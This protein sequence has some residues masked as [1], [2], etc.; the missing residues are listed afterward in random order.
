MSNALNAISRF[1]V[2]LVVLLT[3]LFFL[4][5]TPEFLEF[6]KQYLLYGAVTIG[7]LSWVLRGFFERKLTFTRTPF[8][9]P[10]LGFWLVVLVASIFSKDHTASFF[11]SY[12]KLTFGFVPITFYL[13]LYYLAVNN[14]T[15][16]KHLHSVFLFLGLGGVLSGLYFFSSVFGLLAPRSYLPSWNTFSGTNVGFGMGQFVILAVALVW[17]LQ[18]QSSRAFTIFWTTVAAI[19]FLILL[20]LGYKVLFLAGA[21]GIGIILIF[22]MVN[23]DNLRV[24]VASAAL[25]MFLIFLIFAIFGGLRVLTVS[26]LPAEVSLSPG[27]SWNIATNTL[28]EGFG[29]A[30]IGSG[31]GTFAYD[32]SAHRPESFNQNIFW[33]LR[34]SSPMSESAGILATLGV[35]GATVLAFLAV[36]VLWFF[37][38]ARAKLIGTA[39]LQGLLRGTIGVWFLLF[40]LLFFAPF[41]TVLWIYFFLFLALVSVLGAQMRVRSEK[42]FILSFEGTPQSALTTSFSSIVAIAVFLVLAIYLGRFYAAE[43]HFKQGGDAASRQ[44]FE[45]AILETGAAAELN[46]ARPRYYLALTRLQFQ[47]ALLTAQKSE[48]N[49][50]LVGQLVSAAVVN[51]RRATELAPRLSAAWE[52]LGNVYTQVI[53]IAPD[54]RGWAQDAYARA[55]DLEPTNPVLYVMRAQLYLGEEKFEEA[56]KDVNRAIAL[57]NNYAHAYTARATILSGKN[58]LIG[59]IEAQEN[60]FALARGDLNIAVGLAQLYYNRNQ[61][62]DWKNAETLL[63]QIVAQ[64]SDHANALFTLGLLY[65]R[66]G[67]VGEALRQFRKVQELNPGNEEVL[68]KIQQLSGQLTPLIPAAPTEE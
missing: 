9:L 37:K 13:A 35:L 3:P 38:V 39:G 10:L 1:T 2:Y 40:A 46:P 44:E 36:V 31:P 51:A 55:L 12:D 65:E 18:K 45:S 48:S 28:G 15:E 24:P 29:R 58:D 30:L 50:E 59:A 52:Q 47:Y 43:A 8:D 21:I 5:F 54:A 6:G 49:R 19:A 42:S 22:S 7:I 14:V 67:K 61:G 53:P 26:S 60:A 41:G 17:L 33:A 11:G 57:K 23:L 25:T 34:F 20:M 62:E 27:T 32:F 63:T 16:K 68:K 56:E 4:P 66:Q 64:N